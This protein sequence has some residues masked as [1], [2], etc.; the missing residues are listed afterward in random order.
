[1]ASAGNQRCSDTKVLLLRT[2]TGGRLRKSA[3]RA[4]FEEVEAS[5]PIKALS[6]HY[7]TQHWILRHTADCGRKCVDT[8]PLRTFDT[9]IYPP[10]R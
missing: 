4:R 10:E 1:M 9:V 7:N 6:T 8:V 3:R 5:E 2:S